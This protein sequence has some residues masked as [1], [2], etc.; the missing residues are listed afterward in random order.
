ML[1]A[2]GRHL[3]AVWTLPVVVIVLLLGACEASEESVR[4]IPASASITST[5]PQEVRVLVV[6]D[7]YAVGEGVGSDDA[8]PAQLAAALSTA[9]LHVAVE[10][11]GGTGW[12]SQRVGREM[13]RADPSGPYDLVFVEVGI[14]DHF[15]QFGTA[16]L[17][18][19]IQSL[20]DQAAPLVAAA[21][22]VVVL[23]IVDWRRTPRGAEY[24]GS[25]R[26]SAID[27][28]NDV[29]ASAAAQGGHRY[30]DVTSMSLAQAQDPSLIADDGLHGSG[31]LY[32]LWVEV[33]LPVVLDAL[34]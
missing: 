31:V 2:G 14:N 21:G 29:L 27:P 9:Q 15:N 11:I 26:D 6:G 7:S 22:D 24:S 33:M 5:L 10:V 4:P 3:R 12:T 1:T 34:G 16:Q 32:T 28:Y 18:T 19:G 13:D 17:Q 8:W 20:L 23:S 30:V 25:W